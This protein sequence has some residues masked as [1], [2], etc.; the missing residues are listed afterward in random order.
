MVATSTTDTTCSYTRC[1]RLKW[2]MQ[3]QRTREAA[4]RF[5]AW[6]SPNAAA[7]GTATGIQGPPSASP[8][9]ALEV[10]RVSQLQ[11]TLYCRVVMG[12][13]MGN[14]LGSSIGGVGMDCVSKQTKS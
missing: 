1:S 6:G 8:P 14:I 12:D 4:R 10:W 9:G 5:E 3:G 2:C 13:V 11:S 7:S